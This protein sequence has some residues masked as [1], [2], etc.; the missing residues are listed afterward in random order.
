[1]KKKSLSHTSVKLS[2]VDKVLFPESKITKGELIQYYHEVAEVM[3]PHLEDRPLTLHRFPD[4]IGTD[5]FI[6]QARGDYFPSWIPG[7][8][9]EHGGKT[10]QVTHMLADSDEA[11]VY[12]ANQGAVAFHRW[13]SQHAVS[14]YPDMLVFDLD[15]PGDSFDDVRHGAKWVGQAMSEIGLTPYVMTTGS[16]GLHVVAP[17]RPEVTFDRLRESAQRLA[18]RLA[19]QYPGKLTTEQRLNKRNGRLYLDVL[20]NAFGQTAVAPYSVRAKPGAPVATPLDWRELGNADLH[21]Q[22]YTLK[23]I[24]K[25]LA[26]KT[27][28]WRDMRRHAVRPATLEKA[29]AKA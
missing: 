5:G 3:V 11:L 7:F 21:S 23:N 17:V 27:D 19:D 28:P 20:R 15:P 13:L 22:S 4:G 12:L 16:T 29:L 24:R 6:Q 2:H 9:V 14:Q 18:A 26:N 1:M 25:R 8:N 10:G